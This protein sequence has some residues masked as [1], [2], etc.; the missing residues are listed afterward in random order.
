MKTHPTKDLIPGS[1]ISNAELNSFIQDV[2]GQIESTE[3]QFKNLL[4]NYTAWTDHLTTNSDSKHDKECGI[5]VSEE[6]AQRKDWRVTY[7]PAFQSVRE[8]LKIEKPT[9]LAPG[10]GADV[11]HCEA[12][13]DARS[14]INLD[15]DF[16][17]VNL[18]RGLYLQRPEIKSYLTTLESFNL[19][20]PV[21]LLVIAREVFSLRNLQYDKIL[22]KG[23]YVLGRPYDTAYFYQNSSFEFVG[24]TAFN[25]LSFMAADEQKQRIRV[26]SALVMT[27]SELRLWS[28]ARESYRENS[29]NDWERKGS[30]WFYR[31][32]A[33]WASMFEVVYSITGKTTDLFQNFVELREKAAEETVGAIIRQELL[34]EVMSHQ[35]VPPD[36][37]FTD[38]F[39]VTNIKK[40]FTQHDPYTEQGRKALVEWFNE[41]SVLALKRKGETF[42]LKTLPAMNDLNALAN[43]VVFKYLGERA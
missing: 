27:D 25:G 20:E 32:P 19:V 43:V 31:E 16:S 22:K 8:G 40:C 35:R 15:P 38:Y 17:S 37:E 30:R 24:K 3:G 41:K 4:M 12:F 6:L 42:L 18:M 14:I 13:S 1:H 10:H 29:P 36:S 11:S 39:G 2:E 34:P 28:E 26:G 9:I 7:L 21:D 5:G 33:D 23:G